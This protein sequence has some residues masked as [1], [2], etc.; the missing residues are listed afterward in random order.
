MLCSVGVRLLHP[1]VARPWERGPLRCSDDSSRRRSTVPTGDPPSSTASAWTVTAVPLV[2]TT[3]E[4]PGVCDNGKS[5]CPLAQDGVVAVAQEAV[6]GGVGDQLAGREDDDRTLGPLALLEE[7]LQD[8]ALGDTRRVEEALLDVASGAP[9]ER[10]QQR[11]AFGGDA[12]E[13]DAADGLAGDRVDDWRGGTH[14]P[15]QLVGEVLAAVHDG[16]AAVDECRADAVRPHRSLAVDES[17]GQEDLVESDL[18]APGGHSTVQ[19]LAALIGEDEREPGITDVG[20]EL[21]EDGIGDLPERTVILPDQIERDV[22]VAGIETSGGRAPPRQSDFWAHGVGHIPPGEC[23]GQR[24]TKPFAG[25]TVVHAETWR[26]QQGSIDARCHGRHHRAVP[27]R[28]RRGHPVCR[29]PA[30]QTREFPASCNARWPGPCD[31]GSRP[32]L[33]AL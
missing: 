7:A 32:C 11:V 27:V 17:L 30:S 31:P 4:G 25:R 28:C 23:L 13:T 24:T 2:S 14:E 12:R 3:V 9:G 20:H 8:D 21:V 18:E 5:A 6:G 10:K 19:H 33:Y 16:A 29:D 15:D 1:K 26:V 22:E